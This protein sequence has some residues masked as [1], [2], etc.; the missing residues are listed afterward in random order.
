MSREAE[1]A[2]SC[3]LPLRVGPNASRAEVGDWQA[4]G[5]LKVKVAVPPEGGRANKAVEE[6]LAKRLGLAKR[7]V[8][9]EQGMSSREKLVRIKGLSLEE[10]R[11]KLA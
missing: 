11:A 3:L 9:V 2:P 4:D 5:R 1:D 6:L 7:D 10:V 8:S